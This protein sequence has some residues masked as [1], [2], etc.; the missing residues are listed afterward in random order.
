M[1]PFRRGWKHGQKKP[2]DPPPVLVGLWLWREQ[3][4]ESMRTRNYSSETIRSQ[5]GDLRRFLSWCDERS[6]SDPT[7]VSQAI[8]ERYQHWLYY[9]RR[10]DG[11]P[12]GFRAQH[13]ML[14]TVKLF[15]RWLTRQ[16]VTLFN[17]AAEL[18]MP[19]LSRKL[20][21]DILTAEEMEAVLAQ[22]DV[23]TAV[24][25]RDR[26]ILE[27]FYS[28][29]VRRKELAQLTIFDL[30]PNRHTLM[31]REGKGHKDR[32]L[33][34]GERALSWIDKYLIDVRPGCIVEPDDGHL[35]L[36]VDG[37]PFRLL[38]LLSGIVQKYLTTAQVGKKGG[39]H[40]FRHTMA[41]LMLENGADIR[42]IQ[43]MLGH[44][45]LA[46]TEVYTHVSITQ[47]QKIHQATHPAERACRDANQN[48]HG[49]LTAE[50]LE[51]LEELAADNDE[52]PEELLDRKAGEPEAHD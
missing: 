40:L 13:H 21:R 9:Y 24:G 47:L 50:A 32:V 14:S 25:L 43:E 2:H 23:T 36:T 5:A 10:P 6:L 4:L 30:D 44:A 51:A 11:R 34:I 35:F 12:I 37:L 41:T 15:F 28:T 26:A 33:P 48:P 19:R 27:T 45:N 31:V 18:E 46:S 29:G 20:P 42:Y 7:E 39:C 3:Y 8:L 1:K 52:T 49:I 16:H 38:K 22:P 17:P